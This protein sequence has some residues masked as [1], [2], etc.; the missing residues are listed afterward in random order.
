MYQEETNN[1]ER[2][3]WGLNILAIIIIIVLLILIFRTYQ[4]NQER[5]SCEMRITMV[6][7]Y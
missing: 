7:I 1:Q 6:D 3:Y 4:R 2:N 5:N